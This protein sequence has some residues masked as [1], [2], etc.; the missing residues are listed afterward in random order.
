MPVKALQ[1]LLPFIA[2]LC[3]AVLVSAALPAPNTYIPAAQYCYPGWGAPPGN[4]CAIIPGNIGVDS[5]LKRSNGYHGIMGGYPTSPEN[6]VETPFDNYS[7]QVFVALNWTKGKE[8]LPPA[9]GLQGEGPRVWQGWSRVSQVFGNSPVQANC[10]VGA[11]EMLFSIGSKGDRTPS[12]HDEEYIQASTGDPA[13][14]NSGNWTIYERRLNGI[15]IAYLKAPNGKAQWNLTTAAGQSAFATAGATVGFP[16]VSMPGARNGAMEIKAAWRMLDP[17]NHAANMKKYFVV[18]AVVG[19]APDLV[20]RGTQA[21]VAPI[22]AH[23]DLGLVAMHIIQKNP[24]T[25]PVS[26]LNPQ[27]FWTTFEHVDNAPLAKNAC[28]ITDPIKCT[29]FPQSRCPAEL[30]AGAPDYSY[31]DRRYPGLVNVVPRPAPN[32]TFFWNGTEPYAK[33]YLTPTN[34][35]GHSFTGT[36]IARCWQIYRLT[37]EL[38][39]Q[40][41]AKLRSVGSVFANYM[42]IGTQW[43]GNIEPTFPPPGP[44]DAAPN[45]L[46]NTL[47]ETFLQTAWD[48]KQPFNT[49]SCVTCHGVAS[50]TANKT[51][52]VPTDFSFLPG[53]VKAT[54]RR[55]PIG[56]PGHDA[57][58]ETPPPAH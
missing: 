15:E 17:K 43:G 2:A 6:D 26:N 35:G 18:R 46:S 45:Y 24:Q 23:V 38:N 5:L 48:P 54:S 56:M 4:L 49:G 55:P 12:P 44:P 57:F 29:A 37:R 58:F 28:D 27:W 34:D 3:C 25:V 22:C 51:T 31:F 39:V 19:V 7:W 1:T 41:Q 53:L 52:T 9:Q 42:L 33:N 47:L 16:S 11:G 50:F 36:Q 10:Q 40:W 21:I 8:A 32:G 30:L 13:I 20:D 14:D